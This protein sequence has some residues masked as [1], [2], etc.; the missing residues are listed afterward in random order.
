MQCSCNKPC[1]LRQ[2]SG[3]SSMN[4]ARYHEEH[5]ADY[6]YA[7]FLYSDRK[8]RKINEKRLKVFSTHC[9]RKPLPLLPS[10]V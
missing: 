3:F 2:F 1:C 6:F 4:S 8:V 7:D 10:V 9:M 5:I